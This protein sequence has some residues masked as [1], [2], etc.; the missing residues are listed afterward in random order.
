MPSLSGASGF[1]YNGTVHQGNHLEGS[2]GRAY[3]RCS[4]LARNGGALTCTC[5]FQLHEYFG[6]SFVRPCVHICARYI[7]SRERGVLGCRCPGGFFPLFFAQF[8]Y[9]QYCSA[10]I[11]GFWINGHRGVVRD[12][13]V[14]AARVLFVLSCCRAWMGERRCGSIASAF[15]H[16]RYRPKRHA[17]FSEQLRVRLCCLALAFKRWFAGVFRGSSGGFIAYAWRRK[18]RAC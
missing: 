4:V 6:V 8:P 13:I 17:S 16:F 3:S 11:F 12:A 15:S 9:R 14:L 5:D 2:H 7:G 18:S 1:C 10:C